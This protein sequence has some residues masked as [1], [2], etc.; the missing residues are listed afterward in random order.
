MSFLKHFKGSIAPVLL[1]RE[2]TRPCGKSPLPLS[3]LIHEQKKQLLKAEAWQGQQKPHKRQ[4][5]PPLPARREI[6]V[7]GE[8]LGC[9]G[10]GCSGG[11]RDSSAHPSVG[12]VSGDA[13]CKKTEVQLFLLCQEDLLQSCPV[14]THLTLNFCAGWV[15]V[16]NRTLISAE[17]LWWGGGSK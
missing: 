14:L 15:C 11:G 2:F 10:Q 13:H 6:A 4:L 9:V 7:G 5:L 17:L 1:K 3:G 12:A 8:G 16:Y